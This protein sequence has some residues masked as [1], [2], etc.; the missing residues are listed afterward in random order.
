M[1]RYMLNMDVPLVA[2]W[3]Q[4][5]RRK[6]MFIRGK[7]YLPVREEKSYD[8][9]PAFVF[10]RETGGYTRWPLHCLIPVEDGPLKVEDF[11]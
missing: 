7:A 4:G 8:G 9:S 5:D 3:M 1:T 6:E 11:V 10:E 2:D